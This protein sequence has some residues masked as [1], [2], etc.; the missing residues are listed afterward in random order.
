M[1]RLKRISAF[2]EK[3]E[4]FK[5][6]SGLYNDYYGR[7]LN[8]TKEDYDNIIESLS[9]RFSFGDDKEDLLDGVGTKTI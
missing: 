8:W 5:F 2:D 7:P 4:T 1:K 3:S 9:W 6:Y